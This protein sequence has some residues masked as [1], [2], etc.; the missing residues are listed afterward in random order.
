VVAPALA[1]GG[2]PG[3][4][5]DGF[6]NLFARLPNLK[7]PS[8]GTALPHAYPPA[9]ATHPTAE[10][11]RLGKYVEKM[12]GKDAPKSPVMVVLNDNDKTVSNDQAE[13][14]V[15]AWKA[16]GTDVTVVRLPKGLGLPHDVVD[17]AQPKGKPD[18]V[19]PVLVALAEGK[20]PPAVPAS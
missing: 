12:A 17:V 1:V 7:L 14:L 9:V 20:T 5:A 8:G 2:V 15:D 19:Y 18:V 6:T 13:R 4:V 16:S 11:F 10:M 3:F